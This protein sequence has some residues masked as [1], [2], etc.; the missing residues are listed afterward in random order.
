MPVDARETVKLARTLI[1]AN[2]GRR[3]KPYLCPAGKITVGIGRNLEDVGLSGKE[4]DLLFA[5]DLKTARDACRRLFQQF[6]GIDERR[7]AALLDVAFNLGLPRLAKFKNMRMAV[8]EG[9]WSR[10]AAELL[11]SRYAE[12]VPN[13]A[14]CNAEILRTGQWPAELR[15]PRPA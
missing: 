11:D 5:N 12:Q 9:N 4:I 8:D 15:D 2:E 7:Q 3:S 13:R 1:A 10:A 14:R 6:D